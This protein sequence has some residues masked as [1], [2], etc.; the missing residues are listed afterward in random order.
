MFI[1]T[2]WKLFQHWIRFYSRIINNYDDND[3]NSKK[4]KNENVFKEEMNVKI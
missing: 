4:N 2:P 1:Y 3:N